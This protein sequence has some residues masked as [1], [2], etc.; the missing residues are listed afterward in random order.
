MPPFLD[1]QVPKT[2]KIPMATSRCSA[3]RCYSAHD[4]TQCRKERRLHLSSPFFGWGAGFGARRKCCNCSS[5]TWPWA[6]FL[7]TEHHVWLF[8]GQKL[9]FFSSHSLSYCAPGFICSSFP[10]FCWVGI[11]PPYTWIVVPV[12]KVWSTGVLLRVA[13][14][15]TW[16]ISCCLWQWVGFLS[17]CSSI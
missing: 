13:S 14:D 8:W 15:L 9:L 1:V 6:S 5:G 3:L 4:L 12:L 7:F 11:S 17:H 10:L 2:H 16:Q